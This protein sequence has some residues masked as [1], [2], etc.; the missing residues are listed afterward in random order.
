MKGWVGECGGE[1][2]VVRGAER[3]KQAADGAQTA[4]T[5]CLIISPLENTAEPHS[6]SVVM[7]SR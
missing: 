4:A 3:D 5:V 1:V 6:D 7:K 2:R